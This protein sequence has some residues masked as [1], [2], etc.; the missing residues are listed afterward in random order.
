VG[1]GVGRR[2]RAEQPRPDGGGGTG[3][4]RLRRAGR[5]LAGPVR[6]APGGPA[7]RGRPDHR[8]QLA[9]G[10][11]PPEPRRRLGRVLPPGRPRGAVAAGAGGLVAAGAARHRLRR[12]PRPDPGRPRG[13]H[14]PRRRH[15]PGSGRRDRPRARLL[16]GPRDLRARPGRPGR[17]A[18][19][20]RGAGRTAPA[21]GAERGDAGPVRP[22]GRP[23]R[24]DP[25]PDHAPP[26]GRTRRRAG[27]AGQP[28]RGGCPPVRHPRLRQPGP[29]RPRRHR[30]ERDDPA[31]AR[32]A[33]G[34]VAG[35]PRRDLGRVRRHH[36]RLRPGRT[37]AGSARP[38][39]QS[40]EP[41]GPRHRSRRRARHQAD[42]HRPGR[43]RPQRRPDPAGRRHPLRR[44]HR[45][46]AVTS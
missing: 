28:G 2:Q 34:A 46:G 18:R 19:R 6:R 23:A 36:R 1:P 20:R 30:A 21:A 35:H 43:P 3:P 4:P 10:D 42:R 7:R 32:P 9:A 37:A 13:P 29:A 33:R 24:L 45:P 39:R 27:N 25:G 11:G 38:R 26:P 22:A 40:R 12:H 31:A 5:P 44:P 8:G 15:L 16:G 14:G 41:D 17:I